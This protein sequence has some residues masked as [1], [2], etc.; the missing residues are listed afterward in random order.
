MP[1]GYQTRRLL[2]TTT[3]LKTGAILLHRT[4][5]LFEPQ[6]LPHKP[7]HKYFKDLYAGSKTSNI[8]KPLAVF[9]MLFKTYIHVGTPE[10]FE[11][12]HEESLLARTSDIQSKQ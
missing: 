10:M 5:Q 1:Q 7:L 9:A 4:P 2:H 3:Y 12:E 8:Y 11:V 6:G